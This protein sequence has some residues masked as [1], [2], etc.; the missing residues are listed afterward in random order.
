V[1]VR[2]SKPTPLHSLSERPQATATNDSAELVWIGT[3]EG[4]TAFC[5]AL[6][7]FIVYQCEF[8][9]SGRRRTAQGRRRALLAQAAKFEKGKGWRRD[10]PNLAALFARELRELASSGPK[11]PRGRPP[12]P[13]KKTTLERWLLDYVISGLRK[14]FESRKRPDLA[15]TILNPGEEAKPGKWGGRPTGINTAVGVAQVIADRAGIELS[16]LALARAADNIRRTE[17]R[18]RRS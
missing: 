7:S 9:R 4:A 3:P 13:T 8:D 15:E 17:R 18:R 10:N 5:D 2:L 6:M 11:R 1:E 16:K 14:E 12:G